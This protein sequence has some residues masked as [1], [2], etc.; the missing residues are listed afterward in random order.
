VASYGL[1]AGDVNGDGEPD[2]AVANRIS[3]TL[4]VHMNQGNGSLAAPV[5]CKAPPGV[6]PNSLTLADLDGDGPR[7]LELAR[8]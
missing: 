6:A 2:V 8:Q 3:H 1:A 5:T 4:S 7:R